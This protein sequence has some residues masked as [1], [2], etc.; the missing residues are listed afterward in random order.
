M[1]SYIVVWVE[2]GKGAICGNATKYNAV[3][4]HARALTM[5]SWLSE[6]H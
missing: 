2:G 6:E 5:V 4:K 3:V 1:S